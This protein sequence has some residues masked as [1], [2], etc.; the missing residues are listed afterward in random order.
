MGL[1]KISIKKG[2]EWQLLR[3]HPWLFSGAISQ[4]PGKAEA[5]SLVDLVDLNGN[6]VARGYY[7]ANCDIAVRVLTHDPDEVIDSQFFAQRIESAKALRRQSIDQVSTNVYRLIN[8]EG[9]F[10]PGYIV[11]F[12]DDVL[13]VQSHTAGSDSLLSVFLTALESVMKP[14]AVVLRNEAAARKR[15]GLLQEP[16]RVI[17]GQ[18]PDEL[19]VKENN[20]Q[21]L[22]DPLQGQK[23]GFFSDQRD[24]RLALSR[25]A[26]GLPA[27]SIIA[28]CFCY[29]SGFS[30]AMAS[31]NHTLR[32]VNI[33]ESQKALLLSQRNIQENKLDASKHSFVCADAFKWLEAE[34]ANQ[35]QFDVVILD[36][37]AFA[38][39]H[40]EKTN[41]LKGYSRLN[42]LGIQCVK[43]GGLLMTCSCSGSVSMEEFQDSVRQAASRE[44][45]ALQLLEV[46]QNSC[47]HPMLISA[48]ETGYL[49]VLLCRVN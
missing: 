21:F 36:P 30:V 22:I 8:S 11:D 48:P 29:S 23:T 33:D 10:L 44:G 18:V 34:A 3:G 35:H 24:K 1:P 7:N 5:G 49:K 2:R 43:S 47:D 12:Y 38:K 42:Q 45:R 14:K 17:Q 27:D 6:F 28:N 13:V 32:T 4:A 46:F 40:K 39:T 25:Y 41:A 26:A 16:A 19:L 9:D 37:P 20:W 31:V 15:E